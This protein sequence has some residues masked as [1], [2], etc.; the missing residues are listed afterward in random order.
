MNG[1]EKE[2]EKESVLRGL[3]TT[4]V[5]VAAIGGCTMVNRQAER[6]RQVTACVSNNMQWSD[7]S[8]T[9]IQ[10]EVKP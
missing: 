7:D 8:C 2:Q 3:F 9:P 4:I 1:Q 5:F 6:T 10:K